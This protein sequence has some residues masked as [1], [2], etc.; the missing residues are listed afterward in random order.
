MAE[1]KVKQKEIVWYDSNKN[2]HTTVPESWG[3]VLFLEFV[4]PLRVFHAVFVGTGITC[5]I[6]WENPQLLQGRFRT[7]AGRKQ[8]CHYTSHVS[9]AD[10]CFQSELWRVLHSLLVL[11]G[12]D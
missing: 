10:M 4:C 2:A 5:H 8:V 9:V 6:P 3:E 12:Q 1:W 11:S 7:P